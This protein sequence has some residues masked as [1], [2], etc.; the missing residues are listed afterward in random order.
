ML[1]DRRPDRIARRAVADDTSAGT[2]D[3]TYA[4]AD[5]VATITICRPDVLNAFREQTMHELIAAFDAADADPE[6]GVVVLT[7]A[8]DQAFSTGGDVEWENAF[9]P[10]SGRHTARLLL[11]LGEAVRGT[12]KPV[13]AKVRG[14]CVGGGNELTLLC[15]FVLAADSARF[16]HT[17]SMIGNSPIWFGTQLLPKLV[18]TRR[19]KEIL[20]LGEPVRAPEAERIGW[21]NRAVPE[22]ELDALVADW[23][24]RLL[25]RSPQAMRLTK[26]SL[27]FDGDLTLPSVRHGFETLTHNYGTAEFHEGTTAFLERRTPDFRTS[28]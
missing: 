11:R 21:I 6:V 9:S 8:G 2:P 5:G 17:D 24:E 16:V 1:L 7:G 25:A 22:G 10:A 20:L 15:D 4:V 19:A 18:G 28:R 12:G 14:W 13:I 27:D 26:I 23:C 3:T